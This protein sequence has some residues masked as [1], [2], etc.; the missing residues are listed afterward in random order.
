MDNTP[1]LH[2]ASKNPGK[3]AELSKYLGSFFQVIPYATK[4]P[5]LHW[6]EDCDS[7][8]GNARKKALAIW[9]ALGHFVLADDSGLEVK[10]LNGAPGVFSARY[11]GAKGSAKDCN[12]KLLKE[13]RNI[14]EAQRQAEFVC[15][16]ALMTPS[17]ECYFFTGRCRGSIALAS[18]GDQGFGYDPVFIPEDYSQTFAELGAKVKSQLSHRH[19]ALSQLRGQIDAIFLKE[20]L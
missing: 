16:L 5:T 18:R 19:K 20:S 13:M 10:A 8:V 17:G 4:S 3:I 12:A 1:L 11:A 9:N 2:I 15:C 14:S 7:F 6:I